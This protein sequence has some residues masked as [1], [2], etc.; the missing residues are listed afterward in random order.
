MSRKETQ[1]ADVDN[2]KK[3]HRAYQRNFFGYVQ[4]A[5]TY[6]I[7]TERPNRRNF[8]KSIC[9][10]ADNIM[11]TIKKHAVANKGDPFLASKWHLVMRF[12]DVSLSALH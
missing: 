7:M 12:L 3:S 6:K 2:S 8:K 5:C 4:E 11:Q 1:E 9:I 10:F